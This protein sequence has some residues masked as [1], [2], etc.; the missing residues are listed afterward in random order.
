MILNCARSSDELLAALAEPG[1][2]RIEA[3]RLAV[4]F[5]HPDDETI[6]CGAQLWRLDGASVVIV[7]DGAPRNL[8]DARRLGFATADEYAAARQRE[9]AAALGLAGVPDDRIISLGVPDQEAALRLLQITRMLT[10]LLGLRRIRSVITHAYEGGHPDHDATAFCVHMAA[11]LRRREGQ[12]VDIIEVPLY[13]LG[14]HGIVRQRF[15]EGGGAGLAL[16][17]TA[18][19]RELKRR[20]V[21]AHRT[22]GDVL[23]PFALEVERFR[24]APD[25]D[26]SRLPNGGRLLYEHHPW[27]LDGCRWSALARSTSERLGVGDGAC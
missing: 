3:A 22:Q 26:F 21:A 17:L 8:H 15:A 13:S 19:Q 23:A 4:V 20:M 14:P 25:Y 7:T 5:A 6:G 9:L 12:R 11:T 27:G 2:P 10:E 24:P 1:L 16:Q 18:G